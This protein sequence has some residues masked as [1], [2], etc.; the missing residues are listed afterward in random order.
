MGACPYGA[1]EE[2]QLFSTPSQECHFW[3]PIQ[4]TCMMSSKY[5]ENE[6]EDLYL[7]HCRRSEKSFDET[8]SVE[9]FLERIEEM[10]HLQNGWLDGDGEAIAKD[11]LDLVVAEV[12][13]RIST[14]PP[15][16]FP[17]ETGGLS[18]EWF[19]KNHS[20]AAIVEPSLKGMIF[21]KSFCYEK[22]WTQEASWIHLEKM[23]NDA[24][25]Q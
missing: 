24:R 9:E 14:C 12:K 23:V 3:S 7:D 21:G 13:K 18:L 17:M 19:F 10:E 5:E 2:C 6:T 8:L 15:H 1:C 22:D 25:K 4:K 20:F 11:V 16:V